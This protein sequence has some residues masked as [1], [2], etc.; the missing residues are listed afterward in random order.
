[1]Y[2]QGFPKYTSKFGND[3]QKLFQFFIPVNIAV[4]FLKIYPKAIPSAYTIFGT[5]TFFKLCVT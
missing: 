2:I 1:M 3:D 4:Q 5:M